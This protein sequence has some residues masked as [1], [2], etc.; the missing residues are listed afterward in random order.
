MI[1][2]SLVFINCYD[3]P[4]G[5]AGTGNVDQHP[6]NLAV[7]ISKWFYPSHIC[8]FVILSFFIWID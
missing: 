7:S 2:T 1:V 6:A 5:E 3:S 8:Y 4:S